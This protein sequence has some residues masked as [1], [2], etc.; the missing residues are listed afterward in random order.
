[1]AKRTMEQVKIG[2]FPRGKAYGAFIYNLNINIGLQGSPTT[3]DVDLINE[4][5]EY[6]IGESDLEATS[7]ISITVQAADGEFLKIQSCFL[8]S[9]SEE[10]NT[11]SSTLKLKYIEIVDLNWYWK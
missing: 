2:S 6:T 7:P 4:T 3:I 1:M 10:K 5:G 9:Y 8:V 11:E